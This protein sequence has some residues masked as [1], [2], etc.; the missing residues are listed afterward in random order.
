MVWRV[1]G[2]A[3]DVILAVYRVDRVHVL[4][5]AGVARQTAGVDFFRRSIL[6]HKDLGF[7]AATR[8]VIRAG[9]VAA[10]ARRSC[11]RVEGRLPVRSLLPTVVDFFVTGLA[12][13]GSQILGRIGGRRFGGR[14]CTGGLSS[15]G[16]CR[17]GSLTSCEGDGEKQC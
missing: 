13:L 7:V 4:S 3:A 5:A 17:W 2:D 9:T 10:L 8:D 1:A 15:V 6:E 14:G 11:F 16:R 12:G